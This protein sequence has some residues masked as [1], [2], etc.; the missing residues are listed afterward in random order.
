MPG[1]NSIKR[2][3]IIDDEAN[4]RHML[5]TVLKK[6]DYAVDSAS[7]GI[8]GL[9]M[10][11]QTRY[12]F[13][14]CDIKMPNMGGME[15]LE[16]AGDKLN[17][18]TV[19]MM[20]AYGSIDTAIDAMK[21]GAYDYISKPFKTD[22]VYLTLK[23][24]EER[25]RLKAE[26]RLLK[27]RIEIFEKDHSF[28]RMVGKN[29]EM[30]DLFQL[31]K[32]AAQYRTTVLIL[33]DSGTGKELVARGIHHSSQR[34]AGP[35]VP[36]NCGG[37]PET[38]LESELFGYRK[39][40]FTG[41]DQNRHGLFREA[42]GGTI[43]L[44]EIGEMP[45][46]LQVKLLR[47]LQDNEVRPLGE[48][49]SVKIDVRVVAAT[50]KNLEEEVRR[51]GFREDLYYRLN[52]LTI[53]LPPLNRRTEDIPI[54]CEHF[55]SRL[56]KILGKEIKGVAPEA[57]SQ[58]LSY[59]WPGNVRELENAIERAM[60][61]SDGL[62]LSPEHFS[63]ESR[64]TGLMNPVQPYFEGLSLKNAQKC[65]EKDLITR[66][67]QQTEGNRTQA[68][69]LLEISHPSLLSKMKVYEIDL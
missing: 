36:V 31:A 33:G 23:K 45:L 40:A 15:F 18:T 54:L 43:F 35:L 56:N 24:A 59:P 68:A 11:E 63:L 55:I 16:A 65:M 53:K 62:Q 17:G 27:E 26:N 30:Q 21:L 25:E 20:S 14:L 50:A 19:I 10:I 66:A 61:V 3:L 52:V 46:T 49:K 39:G 41:A 42:E 29:K 51:G 67:L 47:V 34:A 28:D 8:A 57:M 1:N 13:I 4:M 7:D 69:R 60:V 48:S 38:L 5:T 32:K 2:L 6:A 12:D 22:E 44:D 58:L 64:P 9:K 37:I